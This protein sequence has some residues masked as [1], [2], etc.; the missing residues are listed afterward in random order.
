VDVAPT[1][2]SILGITQPIDMTGKNLIAQEAAIKAGKVLLVILDGWGIG[3]E[4]E[5]NPI[6]TA[7]TPYWDSLLQTYPHTQLLAA[8]QAVGLKV[9]KSGNSNRHDLGGRVIEQDDVG[10]DT[11]YGMDLLHK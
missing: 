8:G 1:I 5:T 4:D 3:S 2:L 6:H 11:L 7:Q 10:L 9:G